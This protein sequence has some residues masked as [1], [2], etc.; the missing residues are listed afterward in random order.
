MHGLR[1]VVTIGD[2]GFERE[3][4]ILVKIILGPLHPQLNAYIFVFT[5][6]D[7]RI[8]SRKVAYKRGGD[9]TLKLDANVPLD[10]GM[11]RIRIYVRDAD[12]MLT[13][14]TVFV[15]RK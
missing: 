4:R 15:F 6:V 11:N 9:S 5:T 7:G 10:K 2:I 1:V 14:E 3:R 12:D 8:K 13:D